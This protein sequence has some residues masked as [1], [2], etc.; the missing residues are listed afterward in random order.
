MKIRV[1]G[2]GGEG[3]F[4]FGASGPWKEFEAT[5]LSRGHTI[6][7]SDMAEG[8]DAV[9]ANSY[10]D[11]LKKYLD[12]NQIPVDKRILVLWEPYVVETTRYKKETLSQF[13][14]FFAPSIQ[15]A[16]KV[17]ARSFKWPQDEIPDVDVFEGWESRTNRAV[18]V[19]GNKF[20]ARKGE[21]YS[22]RRR[23][24]LNLGV[25]R[26]DLFGTK[27]NKGINFDWWHWS[28]SLLNSKVNEI[29][30][31]SSFGIGKKYKNY[32]GATNDKNNTLTKYKIAV[33]IENSADFVSEKLFDALRAGCVTIYVGPNLGQYGILEDTTIQLPAEPQVV[34]KTVQMLLKE[35]SAN[36]EI[37]ARKQRSEIKKISQE[38][39][40][41]Q[42]LS[43]LASAM[44]DVLESN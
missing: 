17:G 9:I 25:S 37:I 19:Q 31:R 20:S 29:S 6:C 18:M 33:V 11:I 43:N 14:T 16:E 26:L 3:K 5:L 1:I 44:L 32:F 38:W 15:W 13:G 23:V 36:L 8:A 34:S 10:S 35:S 2:H 22:L 27:W 42:V 39:N 7:D 41:T 21:L 30:I 28:R 4:P 12:R 40:N 24:I